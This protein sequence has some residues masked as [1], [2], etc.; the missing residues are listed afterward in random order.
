MT[1]PWIEKDGVFRLVNDTQANKTKLTKYLTDRVKERGNNNFIKGI[2]YGKDNKPQRLSTKSLTNLL[3]NNSGSLKIKAS[4]SNTN[5]GLAEIRPGANVKSGALRIKKTEEIT[6]QFIKRVS[7]IEG[8]TPE[9]IQKYFDENN[10]LLRRLY[11]KVGEANKKI[12]EAGIDPNQ[13]VSRGHFA[14]LSHS[15]DS[16]RNLFLE[17][18][19]ENIGK[20]DKYSP[21]PAAMLAIGNPVKEGIDPIENWARDFT[22]WLD[23]PEN[24]GSGVLPQRGDYSDLLEQKFNLITGEQWNKLDPTQQKNA[25]NV[26][27]DLTSNTEKLNQFLP[28]EGTAR[29]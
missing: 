5:R 24:G 9:K 25:L 23:K 6:Q 17:L 7:G 18:L 21:N 12:R 28:S 22:T 11:L 15:I 3:E 1:Q 14:R 4:G 8:S 13:R 20:G 26:I 19:T 10:T 16:P 2:F 27:D 29:R